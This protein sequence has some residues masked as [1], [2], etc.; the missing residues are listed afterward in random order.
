MIERE[1]DAVVIGAGPAGLA[2]ACAMKEQGV[3]PV[4]LER[5]HIL[6]GI[7]PQC[8][9]PGFGLIHFKEE[10]TGPEF[11]QRFIDRANELEVER[12]LDTMVLDLTR[13]DDGRIR[14]TTV[15][16]AMGEV[17]LTAKAV[18]LGMGCR[19]RTR[20]NI[21]IPGTRPAGVYTAGTAQRL[22]NVEGL[23]PGKEVVVLGSGDIGLIMA[24]RFTLEGAKVK[25]VC[26]IQPYLCG[27]TRNRVQCL[28]DY[29]IPLHLGTTIIDVHGRDRV[30]GV[31]IAEVGPGWK[32]VAGTEQYV[33]CDCV[34]VSVGLV[35]ENELSNRLGIEM[36]PLTTG[37]RV[38]EDMATSVPGVYAAGN[39][40]LVNDLVDYVTAQAIT[41]GEAAARY[42]REGAPAGKVTEVACGSGCRLIVPQRVTREKDVTFLLRVT[43]PMEDAVLRVPELG[44]EKKL[45]RAVPGEMEKLRLKRSDLEKAG[46]T[47]TIVVEERGE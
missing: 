38:T 31:T 20:H 30:E 28:V 46:G 14:V 19:E 45:G 16:P 12:M 44:K 15:N 27:L 10:L 43:E 26:E 22:I 7:L 35:P 3:D 40:L 4:I 17:A 41:A 39:V 23:M 32:P 47:I 1:V 18:V 36:D 29:D 9:H 25:M 5:D 11:V 6:G 13:M 8:I 21:T 37:P 33:P 34:V 2:A 42:V 24:R